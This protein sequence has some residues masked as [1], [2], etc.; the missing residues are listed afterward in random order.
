M[1]TVQQIQDR[2]ERALEARFGVDYLI[3]KV[4]VLRDRLAR[5]CPAFEERRREVAR[6]SGVR[7]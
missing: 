5:E 1:E 7:R 4:E 2:L 6:R 3:R